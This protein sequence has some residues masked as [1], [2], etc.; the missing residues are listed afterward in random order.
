MLGGEPVPALVL[1]VHQPWYQLPLDVVVALR[2][3][4]Q[5]RDQFFTA[6]VLQ[7]TPLTAQFERLSYSTI[8][9]IGADQGYNH[10]SWNRA[11]YLRYDVDVDSVGYSKVEDYGIRGHSM[12]QVTQRV[13]IARFS[14]DVD[15]VVLGKYALDSLTEE[16]LFVGNY[17]PH[18]SVVLAT[19]PAL[20]LTSPERVVFGR[21]PRGCGE[22][23]RAGTPGSPGSVM[24]R[25]PVSPIGQSV[26]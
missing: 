8:D 22:K 9:V 25:S 7:E 17:Q 19:E 11:S 1:G 21:P 4:A 20:P 3:R 15:P 26:V 13:R 2:D 23:D 10:H 5:S 6:C 16:L 18:C 24:R 12:Q 14:H